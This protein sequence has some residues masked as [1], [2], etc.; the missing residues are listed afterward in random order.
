MQGFKNSDT[1]PMLCNNIYQSQMYNRGVPGNL[2]DI[3][4]NIRG[5]NS[6]LNH[7]TE[8]SETPLQF[9]TFRPTPMIPKGSPPCTNVNVFKNDSQNISTMFQTR[10]IYGIENHW[11]TTSEEKYRL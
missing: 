10:P 4:S 3:N 1:Q 6:K 11:S 8:D 2:I 9:S 7:C 5:Q